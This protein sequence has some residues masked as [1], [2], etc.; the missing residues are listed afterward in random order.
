MTWHCPSRNT[1]TGTC[2]PASVKTRVIP[3]FCAITPERIV[4]VLSL[5]RFCSELDLDVDASGK[6]KLH[7]RVHRLRRRVHD[8]EQALVRA[9]LELLTALL[10]DVGRT[11]D[12]EFLDLRRQ[13]NRPPHLRTRALRSGHDLARRRIEDAVIERLEPD[14]NVLA[15]HDMSDDGRQISKDGRQMSSRRLLC[16][17]ACPLSSVLSRLASVACYSVILTT[18]PAPTVLPPSRMANRC[19]SSIAIGVISSTSIAALSPGMIISVPAGS[20]T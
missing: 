16:L 13:R 17:L 5:V 2:S 11:V 3:T 4:V 1:V 8:V 19:F 6:I 15:V 12:R 9:H 10:V 7:Q 14:P 20:V 18:T